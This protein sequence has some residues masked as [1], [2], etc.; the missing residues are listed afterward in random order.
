MAVDSR[1]RNGRGEKRFLE[2]D[3]N[4]AALT[5]TTGFPPEDPTTILR[6][7]VGFLTD[8]AGSS[9]MLVNG[10]S[11][12]K[13]FTVDASPNYDRHIL[14]MAFQIQDVGSSIKK[15][16]NIN[17]LSNG[18]QLFY[19]DATLGDIYLHDALTSNFDFVQMCLFN[20]SF[21][22]SSDVFQVKNAAGSNE[23]YVPVLDIRSVFGMLYGVKIPKGSNRRIVFKIRDNVS[24]I[25][26]FDCKVFG[27]D[28]VHTGE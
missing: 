25:D 4:H 21:G 5:S 12:N 27:Y 8:S 19:E 6:P 20:P 24:G 22:R 18:C 2:I 14:T 7:Y 15:F 17:P 10:S 11:D 28:V 13:L 1:I 9:N 26:A 16:G 23:A 3:R